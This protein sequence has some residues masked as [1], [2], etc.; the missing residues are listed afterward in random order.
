MLGSPVFLVCVG[1]LCARFFSL[2]KLFLPNSL[3]YSYFQYN[4]SY[5]ISENNLQRHNYRTSVSFTMK[6]MWFRP[7]DVPDPQDPAAYWFGKPCTTHDSW[8]ADKYTYVST[9][10]QMFFLENPCK[11]SAPVIW[12]RLKKTFLHYQHTSLEFTY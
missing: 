1:F 9:P 10:M 7:K 6:L 12:L 2:F 4:A 11:R 8:K 5:F 3:L